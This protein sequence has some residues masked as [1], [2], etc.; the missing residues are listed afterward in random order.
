[1]RPLERHAPE[2]ISGDAVHSIKL[3][4]RSVQNFTNANEPAGAVL[5]D[6]AICGAV[7]I[8]TEPNQQDRLDS[9]RVKSEDVERGDSVPEQFQQRRGGSQSRR[10]E[11]NRQ[12]CP[13]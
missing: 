12:Q 8:G 3:R 13:I 9:G 6:R 11:M 10:S 2:L 1:M 4:E 7:L 5:M